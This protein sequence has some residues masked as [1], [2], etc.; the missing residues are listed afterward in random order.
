MN[1]SLWIGVLFTI[2]S[3]GFIAL[4]VVYG[5]KNERAA[6]RQFQKIAAANNLHITEQNTYRYITYI[7]G[8]DPNKKHLVYVRHNKEKSVSACVNLAETA[9]T[10]IGHHPENSSEPRR[11][12]VVL[13]LHP[14][15]EGEA[16]TDLVF[17]DENADHFVD[18]KLLAIKAEEWKKLVDNV[19]K[20]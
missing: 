14:K 5:K 4:I 20:A 18:R 16:S 3:I 15:N 2:A 13:H 7:V 1:G 6:M 17:F 10:G 9:S 19:R 12:M 8:I 11:D